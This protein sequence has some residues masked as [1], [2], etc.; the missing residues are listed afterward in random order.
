M[1][2]RAAIALSLAALAWAGAA[3]AED[4]PA[5]AQ[6]REPM[7][8]NACLAQHGPKANI[9]GLRGTPQPG[10]GAHASAREVRHW[11]AASPAKHAHG[12]M[13]MEFQVR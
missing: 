1:A 13:H 11:R 3:R 5:C 10:R 2:V 6:Y 9:G 7:A 12:R 8:Y 4:N